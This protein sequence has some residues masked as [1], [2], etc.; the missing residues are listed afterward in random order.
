MNAHAMRRTVGVFLVLPFLTIGGCAVTGIDSGIDSASG[1]GIGSGFGSGYGIG[2]KSTAIGKVAGVKALG[3][4]ELDID[5]YT[6]QPF[7]AE[8]YGVASYGYGM[9]L[10]ASGYPMADWYGGFGEV[11]P[12]YLVGPTAI[13]PSAGLAAG[14][15]PFPGRE[16]QPHP[17]PTLRSRL[18][19]VTRTGAA[20]R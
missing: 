1:S 11:Y 6:L 18:G 2:G 8:R 13:L 16:I 15:A 7:E 19:P 3:D 20:A 4:G 14:A 12:G 17:G 10:D 5:P 9:G